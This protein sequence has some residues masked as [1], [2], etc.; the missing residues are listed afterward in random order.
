MDKNAIKKFAVWA[1]TE[2]IARVSLKGVEYGI[3]EDNIED[4]N[5]DS[6]GGKVLTADEKKQ[7]Q[8]LIAEINDK[9]YKQV[10]EEVAYTW[11]N[12]FSALRFMEVNGYL[13]SHVRVFTDEENNFK[14]QIITE[15]IHLDLDGLD[16]EK[17][18]KLKDAEKTEELYKYLL[19]VQCNALNKILPGMFQKIADYTELLLP[20]N[21]LREGSVIQQMIELIPEDDWKDAVQII[22]WLY[23]YYNSEKKDDVFAALKKN[24]KI[25]KENIPAATQ[26]FTPDWIVR[27]MVENSLGRLWLEGHPD[28]KEQ[29]LP[30]E[31]EQST[32]ADG[33]RE[34]EDTK[35]HYY[36]EE[37]EQEP[38]VQE[39]LA[40]IRKEYAT[41]TPNQLKVID[42]CSGSGHILAYMFD[43]LMKI[44][45]SYGYTTREAVASIVENNLYGLDIDD[46]A[47]QLAYFAVMMKARQY[48]R[49]F[50]SRGIQ[51]HVYAIVESNHVDKFA[52]NYFCNGDMKLTAA[53][54]TIIKELHDAKEYGSIVTVTP[55]DWSV[56]YDRFAEITVDINMSR[57]TA[58]RELLPL[59]QVAEALSQKY[60]VVVTNP[61][62]MGSSGMSAKLSDYV[63]KN[64]PDSKSDLF[65]VFIEHCG[66]MAKKNGYQAMITQQ[67]WMFIA[68]YERLREK[69][70][71]RRVVNML[72][73]GA[74]AFNEIPGE[75][76]QTA[77]FILNLSY[78]SEYSGMYCKLLTGKS[79]AEKEKEFFNPK[80]R[81]ST[82]QAIFS[83]IPRTE[84]IYWVS[85]A[86]FHAFTHYKKVR[87]YFTVR[88]G[89]TTGDNNR[90]LRL[91]FEIRKEN[92]GRKWFPCNKGGTFRRWYGNKDY[93]IDW[94][95]NGFALKNFTDIKTGKLRSTLRNIDFNFLPS[96]VVGHVASGDL[97]FRY[98][99]GGF[100]SE[101]AVNSI[102]SLNNEVSLIYLLGIL[103]SKS[104]N[105]I[106]KMLSPTLG[107]SPEDILNIPIVVRDESI[108]SSV[109]KNTLAIS[110][111]D[112][113]AFETSWDFQHHPFRRKVSTI[114]EAFEQWQVECDDRF[115]QLKAN[116]EELNRIFID[117]YGLQDEL[118]PEVEDK[119]VTV[120]K[121]ELGRD[122][123]SFI[124]YAIGCMFG[125]YSL[126]VDGLAYAGG[127][128]EAS[129][130]ASF[131]ADKDNIIPICD[132]EY[133][134]DD[135]VGLFVEFV[136][137]VY[138]ADTLDENLKFIADALG[139]KGQPKEVIRNYFLN[140][141]YKDHCKIYQ[142]R[143]IY[144][145]F[146]SGKKNGF[147]ALIYMHRYQPDTI[148]R[149]RTDY[150]HE[151]QARYRTAI[152]DLEQRI[153]NAS[154]GER[155]KLNRKL[156]TL[157]AQEAEIRTYEEKIHHLADQMISIDLDDGVKK[158]YAIFQDVLAKIK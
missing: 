80:Q 116:E 87:D 36:L 135:I 55:Q 81:F 65:A 30:T 9:G 59:V 20:D 127:E 13:P 109:V 25:T 66:Y 64:Y 152:A 18:Y 42:P 106:S 38:E 101:S 3:T 100:I 121:A 43:V 60:D 96:V 27:Y 41:L 74:R 107:V 48:D 140:D 2:L 155:V 57:D 44:Y 111:I 151:Q 70:L 33:N 72:H 77:S 88:N 94:E 82:K 128:W 124:S 95:N 16:M 1:R 47:A 125:R 131:A 139:G 99:E 79:E 28:V 153:A 78:I 118:T 5:A 8:A 29:L 7:R 105:Y 122:I 104:C 32:Y 93:L 51:P 129:K 4:A 86:L 39:Q 130:Y 115:N 40:E 11:F 35:W 12:R 63:K 71:S 132:D 68:G 37:A 138:G 61:P 157:Q 134:E 150:V 54:D 67:V 26:L 102:Y 49:R 117:I 103:N 92:I 119:D 133:F 75:V 62:Y 14:P 123:R 158:N 34:S 126:E 97:P 148:A 84:Y 120:R 154:T 114:A 46:R 17:V 15:A 85:D 24:V 22:G 52:V 141:F 53:M 108:V 146:D 56:L 98:V 31:E 89:L 113:D 50:F 90:F 137:T 6:V 73:L 10:M 83:G 19:I 143:P 69:L 156:T 76:V 91:W 23:Q 142:K 110:R 45:E 149:I 58:L 144:W 145:L 21:L 136:K 112:W 147:K